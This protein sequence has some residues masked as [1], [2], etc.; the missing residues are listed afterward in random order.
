MKNWFVMP[1]SF[2]V[3][4]LCGLGEVAAVQIFEWERGTPAFNFCLL[5]SSSHI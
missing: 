2:A 3:D 4:F 1:S 5:R